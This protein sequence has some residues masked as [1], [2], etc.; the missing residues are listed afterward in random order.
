M[1]G[2]VAHLN[3]PGI[4]DRATPT[5]GRRHGLALSKRS[6]GLRPAEQLRPGHHHPFPVRP[7]EPLPQMGNPEIQPANLR[8]AKITL[9]EPFL[10]TIRFPFVDPGHGDPPPPRKPRTDFRPHPA[11]TGLGQTGFPN[12][13]SDKAVSD[14]IPFQPRFLSFR[15]GAKFAPAGTEIIRELGFPGDALQPTEKHFGRPQ[16]SDSG[17]LV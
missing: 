5:V 6:P 15:K 2:V 8:R 3:I 9:Q 1:H 13:L 10:Q 12:R 16:L 17:L 14:R 7:S 11:P 4:K